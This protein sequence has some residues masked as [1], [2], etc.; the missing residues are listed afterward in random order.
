MVILLGLASRKLAPSLPPFVAA[1]A[2]DTLWALTVFLGTGI[3]F[4]R[5]P[6]R[7]VGTAALLFAFLIELS[8]LYHA[9]WI[10]AIRETT[11]GALV[12][13][14]GFLWTDLLC[15]AAG[16]GAGCLLERGITSRTL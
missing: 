1:Y 4:P 2:G 7:R 10:D 8:Q 6:T 11:P 9:P 14:Y 15:Y 16:V 12:L 3:L 13:G 5:W